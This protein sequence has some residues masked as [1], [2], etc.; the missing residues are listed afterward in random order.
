MT[1]ETP[2]NPLDKTN[3]GVSV[4]D[5]LLV[6]EPVALPT[7]RF[8]GAG[9]Y[10]IY[11]TGDFPAYRWVAE[12]NRDG[13]FEAPLYVG[14]AIPAGARKGGF[15][16]NVPSGTVLYSRL[17]EH[18][19]SINQASNLTLDDFTC[20]YLTVEDIWIPLGEA[21]LIERFQPVWNRVVDGFG[22]HAPGRG[23]RNQ[24]RS[25]WDTLHPGRAWAEPLQLNRLS[26]E[27]ITANVEAYV[28]GRPADVVEYQL[29]EGEE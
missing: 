8:L 18:A 13:R 29:D 24:E 17:H 7:D 2:Y 1:A 28:A 10:A 14:R 22:N 26:A 19:V 3:L 23:R 4:A 6:R 16:L 12:C 21:L 9:I 20:R 25:R 5:A 15:G 11:Y 27:Q